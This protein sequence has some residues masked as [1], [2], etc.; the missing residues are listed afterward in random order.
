MST[1]TSSPA[2]REAERRPEA[3]DVLARAAEA[4][5]RDAYAALGWFEGPNPFH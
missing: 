1:W 4:L 3:S 5:M 2:P